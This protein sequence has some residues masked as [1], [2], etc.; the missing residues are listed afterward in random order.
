MGQR[1]M[2]SYLNDIGSRVRNGPK[3]CG[4]GP[5]RAGSL[6]AR[7]GP[8]AVENSIK[9]KENPLFVSFIA[10]FNKYFCLQNIEGYFLENMDKIKANSLVNYA[11]WQKNKK[12]SLFPFKT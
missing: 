1:S 6:R 3:F 11:H 8:R 5:I 7:P 2:D 4:L 9:R 10:F 12:V